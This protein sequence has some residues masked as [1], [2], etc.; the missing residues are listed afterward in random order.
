MRRRRAT[1]ALAGALLLAPAVLHAQYPFGKNKVTYDNRDWKVLKTDH[2]DIY[3]YERDVNLIRY[4]APLVE[5][6]YLE[7]AERF[8]LEFDRPVPFVFYAS[9][10]DFMETNI[11]PYLI[12]EYT[13]GFTDLMRGRIA[14]PFTGQYATFRHV[15]RH[16][17]VHAFMLEKLTQ[18]M[19]GRGK[20]TYSHPPLWFVEGMAEYFA[21]SPQ[22]TQGRMFVRDALFHGRLPSLMELWRIEG[23]FMMYK[24]GEAVVGYIAQNFG[25]EAVIRIL[26][27]W[28]TADRF[29]Y[30]LENTI[31]MTL[32]Q[33]DDAFTK[34]VKRRYYPS[35]LT[36]AFASDMGERLTPPRSFHSRPCAGLD[37]EGEPV[38]FATCAGDGA[39]DIC[40]IALDG[41]AHGAHQAAVRGARSS[42]IESIPAF[43]SKLE[44]CG[45]TLLFVTKAGDR[46]RIYLWDMRE[47]H[48]LD[49]LAFDG[50]ELIASPTLSGDRGRV[51][52]SAI[53]VTGKMDLF[54]YH[55]RE[56]RLE[57]LTDD[58]FSEEDPDFHP[59]EEVILFTSDRGS[60]GARDRTHIYRMDLVT[61]EVVAVEGGPH[62]DSN[63]EW[64]PDGKSFLFVS[65]REGVSNVYHHAGSVIVR[66]TNAIG[67]VTVPAFL[68]G[69]RE[70]VASVYTGGEFH[71]YRLP[72]RNGGARLLP[73]RPADPT[74]VSWQGSDY[75]ESD[76]VS[77][78]YRTKFAVDFVGAGISVDPE[79]GAVGNGGALVLRDLLGNHEFH[80]FFA[81]TTNDVND[82]WKNFNTGLTYVNLSHR[83]HYS[84]SVFHLNTSNLSTLE[85]GD[86]EKRVGGAAGLIYPI[87]RFQR[88]ETSV[89]L[90][91]VE[92][93][94]F[95]VIPLASSF[96]GSLFAS[97]VRDNTLW[98]IGGPLTGW[99]YYLTAGQTVDFQSNGFSSTSMQLDLRRYVRITRR[100]ALALRYI[101]RNAWGNDEVVYFQGGA[102]SLRGYGYHD[103]FG[104][105][106]HLLNTE[107]RFPLV[108]GFALALP[109]GVIEMPM[110]RGAIFFDTGR[111]LRNQVQMFD[112]E[113]LSSFGVGVELNLGF[114]PVVRLNFTRALDLTR[115][116]SGTGVELFIG[117]NY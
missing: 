7:L 89:V 40:R 11:L 43:R 84:L 103:F 52:F 78:E 73:T 38:V 6:T 104:R 20:F 48:A 107:L 34:Y 54:M 1:L 100:V 75:R 115:I 41:E 106:T 32:P 109:F 21:A 69:G 29:S 35:V 59:H 31:G 58:G 96:T 51:V 79:A 13:G 83:I 42:R 87:D 61:R 63:P 76:F 46:D 91:H 57:R 64:S 85:I 101:T 19:K 53:D 39:I 26:E 98:T 24:V 117:Y 3:H 82:F 112:T 10:Y 14:V 68:P 2:V 74:T 90:R 50:L 36:M 80:F 55:L 110:F 105:S 108:D 62:A 70:F 66:Q 5:E 113:W 25:E 8:Q 27:S 15:A 67:G 99:R 30:V 65:D 72:V 56:Q 33:L 71:L 86:R 102:W 37:E 94:F 17:M 95:D 114:A 93:T 81:T 111:T 60:A 88:V 49:A 92:R 47:D 45:D 22:N 16:E 44:A 77:Q 18:V 12:S 9:H 97:Y 4:V 116:Y 23:S 28:W